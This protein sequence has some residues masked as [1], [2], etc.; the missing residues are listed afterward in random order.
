MAKTRYRI[1]PEFTLA[2]LSIKLVSSQSLQNNP[3][4][5]SVRSLIRRIHK[6][7]INKHNDE[8]IQVWPEHPVHQVHKDSRGIRQAKGH[9][10]ELVMSVPGPKSSLLNI[11]FPDPELMI[12][13]SEIYL[14]EHLSRLQLVKEII[15]PGQ[16]IPVLHSHL[17]QFPV[18]YAHPERTVLLPDKQN[19]CTPWRN[20]GANKTFIQ[21]ILQLLLQLCKLCWGHPVRSNRN[22]TS[23]RDQLNTEVNLPRRR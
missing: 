5:L 14:R 8:L 7:V 3:Q 22:R 13:R 23:P 4:M 16:R 18:I 10:Q 15:N 1:K 21:K 6:H 11:L 2:K 9:Y 19:R 17:V 12:S 20:T